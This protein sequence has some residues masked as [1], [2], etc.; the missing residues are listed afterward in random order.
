MNY[1]GGNYLINNMYYLEINECE[2]GYDFYL[3]D[4]NKKAIDGGLLEAYVLL[5]ELYVIKSCL[6]FVDV[7]Y[8]NHEKVE[9]DLW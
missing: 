1:Y 6:E 3:Y 5:D 8:E 4:L 2:L 7:M 9:E